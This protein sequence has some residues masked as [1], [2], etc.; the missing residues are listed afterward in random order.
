MTL[1]AAGREKEMLKFRQPQAM[2]GKGQMTKCSPKMSN[3]SWG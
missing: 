3:P 2:V 1:K